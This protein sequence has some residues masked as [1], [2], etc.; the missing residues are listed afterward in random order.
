M[1]G[2]EGCERGE[3]SR[4]FVVHGGRI[5]RRILVAAADGHGERSSDVDV[6]RYHTMWEVLLLR[7]R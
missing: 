5:D 1:K 3:R 6:R 4:A 2:R 7:A